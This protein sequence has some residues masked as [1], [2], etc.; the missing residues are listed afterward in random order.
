MAYGSGSGEP[1]LSDLTLAFLE[2][3]RQYVV[4]RHKA[5]E[6]AR[7]AI[8]ADTQGPEG[9]RTLFAEDMWLLGGRLLEPSAAETSVEAWDY[10]F[11]GAES[12]EARDGAIVRSPGFVRW[13]TSW[14]PVAAPMPQCA[15]GLAAP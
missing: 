4:S 11:T 7:I 5:P 6:G 1:Y 8:G 2:D 10:V 15:A 3:T 13:G 14:A 9:N 12:V